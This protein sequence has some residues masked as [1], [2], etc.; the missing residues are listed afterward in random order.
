MGDRNANADPE[1]FIVVVGLGPITLHTAVRMWAAAS[2]VPGAFIAP[3]ARE[4]GKELA[5][6]EAAELNRLAEMERFR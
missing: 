5:T 2:R 6:F 4:A 3:V 1:E